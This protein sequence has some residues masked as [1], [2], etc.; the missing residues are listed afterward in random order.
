[1][2]LFFVV[3][4]TTLFFFNNLALASENQST[5]ED[6]KK[7]GDQF[8]SAL[9]KGNTEQAYKEIIPAAGDEKERF[10]QQGMSVSAYMT[11]VREQIGEPISFDL[12]ATQSIKEHFFKQKYLLKFDNAA[13]VWEIN[14]YQPKQGWKLVDITYNTDIEALFVN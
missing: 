12:I 6:I 2:R 8:M 11:K 13:I 7:T 10:T 3:I 9:L 5:K 4:L 1:V 14:Y